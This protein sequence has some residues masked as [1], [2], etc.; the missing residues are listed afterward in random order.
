[1]LSEAGAIP[2]LT[3]EEDHDLNLQS[4]VEFV[5]N[6]K[7]DI[8]V[9]MHYNSSFKSDISGTETYYYNPNSK[10]LASLV[11]RSML[12][13]LG[14]QDRGL[15]QVKFFVIYNSPVPSV[16]V[17]PVYLSDRNEERL[18]TD[19]EFQEKVARSVFDGI[20]QY[21]EVLKKIG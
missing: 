14:R 4:R 3:R 20:K 15:S 17:E 18:A 2:L 11:H 7:A 1:M 5:K 12:S 9:C 13:G 8:L 19:S 6:N 21:F 10:L 16:L